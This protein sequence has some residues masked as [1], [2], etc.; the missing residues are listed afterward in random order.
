MDA[1]SLI[2]GVEEMKVR[3][4]TFMRVQSNQYPPGKLT[5]SNVFKKT[6][7]SM[8]FPFFPGWDM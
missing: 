2:V 6:F 1:N 3:H 5:Y 4:W 7:E 8:I